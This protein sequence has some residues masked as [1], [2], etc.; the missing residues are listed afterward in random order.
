MIQRE[1][2]LLIFFC[3]ECPETIETDTD[4][5]RDALDTIKTDGWRVTKDADDEWI[6]LCPECA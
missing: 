6:H 1:D 3:D 5:F 2:G 4:D